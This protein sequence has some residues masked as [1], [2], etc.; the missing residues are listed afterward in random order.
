MSNK[1]FLNVKKILEDRGVKKSEMARLLFPDVKFPLRAFSRILT[2]EAE[3]SASQVHM[4]AEHLGCDIVDLYEPDR[5]IWDNTKDGKHIFIYGTNFRVEVD[6]NTWESI[7]SY[8]HEVIERGI[9]CN[10]N[11]P[12]GEFFD[13]MRSKIQD[14]IDFA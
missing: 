4:L 5:W 3:L 6:L 10:G 7:L 14:W 1:H 9:F 8:K 13:L 12:I 2:G 11:T